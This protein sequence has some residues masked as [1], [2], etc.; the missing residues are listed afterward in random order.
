MGGNAILCMIVVTS[1][2]VTSRRLLLNPPGG[3]MHTV[4]QAPA[5]KLSW[6]ATTI[7]VQV[8]GV[9]VNDSPSV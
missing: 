8:D 3:V 4:A 5:P 1:S 7:Q 2:G 9:S 6:E